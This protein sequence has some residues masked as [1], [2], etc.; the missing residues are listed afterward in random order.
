MFTYNSHPFCCVMIN[1]LRI[2][3]PVL[4][5]EMMNVL[6]KVYFIL[7]INVNSK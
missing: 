4:L 7:E 3:T 5:V 6:L 1:A 2:P